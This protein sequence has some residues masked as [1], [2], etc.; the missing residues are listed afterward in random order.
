[1]I[2]AV[3]A[4]KKTMVSV[5]IAALMLFCLGDLVHAV[6]PDTGEKAGCES[7]FCDGHGECGTAGAV[8]QPTTVPMA[9]LIALVVV[10]PPQ[11]AVPS[12][13][14]AESSLSDLRSVAPFA[15]RSPP[16]V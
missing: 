9:M 3:S 10:T 13:R 4:A 15:P 1:M 14:M 7:R 16:S 8:M 12:H 5:M 2:M 6:A 11:E